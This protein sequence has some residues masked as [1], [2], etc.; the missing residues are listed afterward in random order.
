MY[1][2]GNMD[3]RALYD[4]FTKRLGKAGLRH[5]YFWNSRHKGFDALYTWHELNEPSAWVNGLFIWPDDQV[6]AWSA[7]NK[8]WLQYLEALKCPNRD[9]RE[10]DLQEDTGYCNGCTMTEVKGPQSHRKVDNCIHIGHYYAGYRVDDEPAMNENCKIESSDT[11]KDFQKFAKLLMK[12]KL[13]GTFTAGYAVRFKEFLDGDTKG[14][15][16]CTRLRL[17]R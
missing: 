2:G 7:F 8:H 15:V 9:P 3:K 13:F 5:Q 1:T 10:Y 4:E 17:G 12:H 6:K 14:N 11:Y 16:A